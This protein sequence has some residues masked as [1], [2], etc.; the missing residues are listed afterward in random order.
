MDEERR[1]R[2]LDFSDAD[3][4]TAGGPRRLRDQPL[5]RLLAVNWLIGAAVGAV[6]TILVLVT[7]T[8]RLR[9]LMFASSEPWIPM[10]LLFF[11]FLVTMCSVAMGT[12]VMLLPKDD[13]DDGP[14]GG[15]KLEVLKMP[16]FAPPPTPAPVRVG[17]MS[18]P[19]RRV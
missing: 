14:G 16:S 12:A 17:A 1:D 2:D 13:D 4:A 5:L 7:D 10:L 11:G 6:L 3:L 18:R 15:S 8:A 19:P 9:T